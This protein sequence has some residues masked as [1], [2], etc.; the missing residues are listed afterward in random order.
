MTA[1]APLR[2]ASIDSELQTVAGDRQ[3]PSIA[4]RR[5]RCEANR[6][7]GG[8]DALTPHPAGRVCLPPH[9][10]NPAFDHA[11]VSSPARQRPARWRPSP[12]TPSGPRLDRPSCTIST[13]KK[14]SIVQIRLTRSPPLPSSPGP[15]RAR[16]TPASRSPGSGP[17]PPGPP[18]ARTADGPRSRAS[19]AAGADASGVPWPAGQFRPLVRD[20]RASHVL[21]VSSGR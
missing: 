12:V 20:S 18:P 21:F 2:I 10:Q 19:G 3:G 6:R 7:A 4:Y 5:L 8:L 15:G 13:P 14:G 17:A 1:T 16:R 9:E 11:A